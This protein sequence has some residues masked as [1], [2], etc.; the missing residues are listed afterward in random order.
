L[1][2][3]L[4]RNLKFARAE[5]G[6][7]QAQL[8]SRVGLHQTVVS[9]LE[10][11]LWPSSPAYLATI[12]EALDVPAAALLAEPVSLRDLVARVSE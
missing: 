2:Q 3:H 7:T 10:R 9:N 4:A 1:Y 6:L 11:G 5:R 8:A 12:A